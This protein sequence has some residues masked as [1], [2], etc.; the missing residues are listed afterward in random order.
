MPHVLGPTDASC[1]FGYLYAQAEDNFAQ[2]EDSTI[3]ALG[4]TAE[5]EGEAALPGDLLV[6]A[7]ELP[8]LVREEYAR[9]DDRS[10]D[11]SDAAAAGLNA[12]L[13]QHPEVRPPLLTR[14]EPWHVF[15]RARHGIYIQ[16]VPPASRSTW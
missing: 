13:A 4:R 1:V 11:L 10:R 3:A 14:F 16:F 8:R 12:F 9:A 15:A 6:R 2:I 7:L 5:M